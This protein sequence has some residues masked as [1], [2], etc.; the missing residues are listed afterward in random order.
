[1]SG[2]TFYS[3]GEITGMTLLFHWERRF[4]THKASL[5]PSLRIEVHVTSQESEWSCIYVK[6]INLSTFYY[7]SNG[8]GVVCI[9]FHI[10]KADDLRKNE[11]NRA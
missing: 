1:M 11:A 8:Y 5:R 2:L 10:I 9:A 4:W 3:H 6:G 7:F